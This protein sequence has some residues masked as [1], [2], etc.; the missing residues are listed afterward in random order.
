MFRKE[1]IVSRPAT[2]ASIFIS[3]IGFFQLYVNGLRVDSGSLSGAWTTWNERVLYFTYDLTHIL[4]VGNNA[5][6]VMLGR[7]WRNLDS[8]PPLYAQSATCDVHERLLKAAITIDSSVV[9]TTD[10]TWQAT[11]SSPVVSDSVYN[12]ETY[13]ARLEQP[14]WDIPGF[15]PAPTAG[16]APAQIIP[17]FMP[18]MTP[19]S[20]PDIGVDKQSRPVRFIKPGA[21]C[22]DGMFGGL[23]AE[24]MNLTLQ[25]V[26]GTGTISRILFASFGTPTG[27]C[28]HYAQGTCSA[29]DSLQMVEN[30]CLG[31]T[32]CTIPA[33]NTFFGGDPCFD[34]AKSLA[35]MAAGCSPVSATKV[36]VDFGENLSGWLK[37]RVKGAAGTQVTLR[38]AEVLQHPPYGPAD[39][40]VYTGN[41]R[42]ALATDIYILKGD[43]AGEIFE[44]HFTYHG[45]Q[46]VEVT[47]Y[48]GELTADNITQIHFHT[49][50]DVTSKFNSSSPILNA[51]QKNALLG[52]GSNQMS[53]PTDCD[54]RDERLGWMGDADLSADS[55]AIN[56]DYSAFQDAF[57]RA[58]L[59]AQPSDGSLPDVVPFARYGGRPADVSWSAALPQ[60]IYVRYKINGDLHPAAQHWGPLLMYFDDLDAQFQHASRD[61][62][63][64]KTP[65]GDWV[66][67]GPKVSDQLCTAFSYIF[68]VRQM[69]ELAQ[70]LNYSSDAA[71]FNA[72]TATL[73]A[74]YNT[75]FFHRDRNCWDNCGQSSYALSLLA[76]VATPDVA[77]AA[78]TALLNDIVS[79]QHNH[80]TVGIIGA[81]ALFALL[82]SSGHVQTGVDLAEQ[83]TQPSWG[84]M[85]Y[86]DVEP[87]TSNL[88]ELWDSPTEGP[89]MNSRNHHMFS[90]ISEFIVTAAG[91]VDNLN[92]RDGL[93][94]RPASALSVSS[95]SVE[96][97]SAC[98]PVTSSYVRSGGVQCA[99]VPESR[100]ASRPGFL[101]GSPVE[102]SCGEHGG[103]F[104]SVDF[105]SWGQADGT[106]GA[107]STNSSCHADVS[108]AVRAA[109]LGH[110][111]CMLTGD[112]DE[113]APVA[114][115]GPRRLVVQATCSAPHGVVATVTVPVA[116]P[117][118]RVFLPAPAHQPITVLE[119]EAG[120]ERVVFGTHGPSAAAG[121]VR[122]ASRTTEGVVVEVG[123]GQYRLRLAS[124]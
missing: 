51:I 13:D 7:G 111:S 38:H 10:T 113:W 47:G 75:A 35:V 71:K 6:G 101:P 14:G 92:C 83:T 119:G 106:C 12:G 124:L 39:G 22:P 108:A 21:D 89:G 27:T 18:T 121:G 99:R 44:P 88:W 28:G 98:G 25:C 19:I 57:I 61:F 97:R 91:G 87:A 24:N 95:A 69:A 2:Q 54:Q 64:W 23:V 103:V 45:F 109:C 55:F 4:K 100:S 3:G 37:L 33:T 15:V 36:V 34:T 31:K 74:D 96:V 122:H 50:L 30:A 76:G 67:A 110:A 94:F 60:N 102:L 77:A 43:P 1:F 114:C 42:S 16:W 72:L 41:L 56:Y 73:V 59:D 80:V 11:A 8:F 90:S 120:A 32:S 66:P 53:V 79:T 116:A 17:C 9:L 78:M 49:M 115:V 84:Y 70:A 40:N 58:M 105:A 48:P 104:A 62:T 93:T 117:G 5:I 112:A 118:A 81:K 85:I 107:F 52:Q 65:Y 86:N 123:S 82:K 68:G 63:K 46:Y 26:P 20:F 29:K